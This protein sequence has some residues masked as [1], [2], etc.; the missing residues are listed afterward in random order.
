MSLGESLFWL[1]AP[2]PL[3]PMSGSGHYACITGSTLLLGR[4]WLRDATAL[5]PTGGDSYGRAISRL[6][7]MAPRNCVALAGAVRL[8]RAEVWNG[9]NKR[10]SAN[11]RLT[12]LS[13]TAN[14]QERI[15][16]CHDTIFT[17]GVPG[18]TT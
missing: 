3:K 13:A 10:R 15:A 17:S 11:Y 12:F 16:Q 9:S 5:P 14:G 2:N 4:R 6:P 7:F 1:F 18:R 8:E